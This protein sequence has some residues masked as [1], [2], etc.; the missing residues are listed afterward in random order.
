MCWRM[1]SISSRPEVE[2]IPEPLLPPVT[3]AQ[4]VTPLIK[5]VGL[6]LLVGWTGFNRAIQVVLRIGRRL[7]LGVHILSA[8]HEQVGA[9]NGQLRS[10]IIRSCGAGPVEGKILLV[11][12]VYH[13]N[14][15]VAF[16]GQVNVTTR[17]A[18]ITVG[19][20]PDIDIP[21]YPHVRNQVVTGTAVLVIAAAYQQH[22]SGK[23]GKVSHSTCFGSLTSGAA[24]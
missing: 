1:F 5:G 22:Q 8:A 20:L 4:V 3:D 16:I 11:V 15:P 13:Q 24:G 7:P 6:R 10:G 19:W 18:E 9:V 21:R 2:G 23:K 12:G 14:A 17:L